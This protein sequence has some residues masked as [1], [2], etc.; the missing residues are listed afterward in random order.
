MAE[1]KDMTPGRQAVVDTRR[2]VPSLDA[3]LRSAPGK[4]AMLRFGR[5]LVKHTL[6]VALGEIR[7]AAER[8]A[9]VPENDEI[10]AR[11]LGEAARSFY[12]IS[13]VINASGVILH[14]GLGRAPLPARAAKAAALAAQKYSD[15]EVDR[16][17][18]S[19]GRR[20]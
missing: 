13:E 15:L 4:K 11:A 19:R 18:G 5:P 14:T 17:T 6:Q 9:I 1:A 2:S 16:E 3:L 8:G 20:T 12:G 7:G 10:L